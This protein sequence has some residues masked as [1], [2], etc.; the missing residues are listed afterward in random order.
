[1]TALIA[2]DAAVSGGC[3]FRTTEEAVYNIIYSEM[4]P[5]TAIAPIMDQDRH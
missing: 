1:M 3:N 2:A 5:D 4:E